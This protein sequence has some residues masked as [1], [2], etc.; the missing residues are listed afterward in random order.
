[1][2]HYSKDAFITTM[3]WYVARHADIADEEDVTDDTPVSSPAE[4]IA[5]LAIS[6]GK[7]FVCEDPSLSLASTFGGAKQNI[8]PLFPRLGI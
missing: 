5:F 6:F 8:V 1:M 4:L 2:R 3:R 7:I